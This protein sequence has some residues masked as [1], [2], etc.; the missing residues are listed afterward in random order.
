MMVAKMIRAEMQRHK[1]IHR[2]HL[3]TTSGLLSDGRK[4]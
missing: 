2:T 1:N 3:F 4:R